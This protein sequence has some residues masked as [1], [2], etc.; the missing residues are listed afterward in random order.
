MED[1]TEQM[2]Q[3]PYALQL[4]PGTVLPPQPRSQ[5]LEDVACLGPARCYNR[6][7]HQTSRATCIKET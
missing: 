2:S 7:T 1:S 6:L 5:G 4:L 3:V